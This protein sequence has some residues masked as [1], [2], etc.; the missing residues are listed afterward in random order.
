MAG[1][2][3]GVL[4]LELVQS[5]VTVA[6]ELNF[7]RAAERLNVTQPPLSRRIQQLERDLGVELFVRS[8]RGVTLTP[9]GEAFL[10]D[11]RRLLAL[12]EEARA[13][14]RRVP[15]GE[16]GTV[17]VGFTAATAY[18][19]LADLLRLAADRLPGVQ[20]VLREMVTGAQLQALHQN[21][22]DLGLIRPPARGSDLTS[23]PVASEPMLAA[24]PSGCELAGSAELSVRDFDGR[25]LVMFDPAGARYFHDLALAAFRSAGVTPEIRQYVTQIHTALALVGA[26]VGLALVPQAARALRFEGVTLLPVGDLAGF[27][28]ELEVC[29]RPDRI[30]PARDRLIAL[31]TD[32]VLFTD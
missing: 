13:T 24:V 10:G 3:L 30:N 6:E 11:A 22:L 12:A 2:A 16:V 18:E 23:L 21:S 28:A 14:V 26:E 9:A 29:W 27:P 25:P 31:L 5:F 8:H 1:Y 20:L 4:S 17:S 19:F 7:G 15:G 32:R